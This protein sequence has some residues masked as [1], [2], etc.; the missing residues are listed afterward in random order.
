MK[1]I[2]DGSNVMQRAYWASTTTNTH[3]DPP[4]LFLRM[5]QSYVK[6]F[7]PTEIIAC[8]DLRS[9][10]NE[11]KQEF[12]EYKSQRTYQGEVYK[13]FSLLKEITEY[14]GVRHMFPLNREADDIIYYLATQKS[15]SAIVVSQDSDIQQI[16]EE[17]P[18][19][20]VYDPAKKRF[21]TPE[22]L[23]KKYGVK[24]GKELLAWKTIKGDK[25]DNI[26]GIG[27]RLGKDK[28]NKLIEC[29]VSNS[30]NST[31]LIDEDAKEIIR[32]NQKLMS[33]DQVLLEKEETD[34]YDQQLEAEI[35][36]DFEMAL[37]RIKELSY[38]SIVNDWSAWS[39][40]F[41]LDRSLEDL[42]WVPTRY[43]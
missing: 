29:V 41:H 25:A 26:P 33:L 35:K 12:G 24:R 2:L 13:R 42:L 11:R 36:P 3:M 14:L 17:Y 28:L 20:K 19:V 43:C 8:W 34:Y 30:L 39:S 7:K 10:V 6:Q 18:G 31:D 5:L 38:D 16:V 32:R 1:L 22:F 9:G 37:R 21:I 4:F 15:I 40:Y 23:E 27:K